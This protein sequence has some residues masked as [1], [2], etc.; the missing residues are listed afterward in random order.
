[1]TSPR[2][3]RPRTTAPRGRPREPAASMGLGEPPGPRLPSAV[4]SAW[5]AQDPVGFLEHSRRRFGDAFSLRLLPVGRV[6]VVGTPALVHDVL[7]GGS[8]R[9][10][11]GAATARLLPFLGPRS[12]LLL[13]GEAHRAQRRR[14]L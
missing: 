8:D 14:L 1:M 11:A 3:S 10:R 13:D 9:F 5:L 4:Q 2:F 12:P 7:T 6:V